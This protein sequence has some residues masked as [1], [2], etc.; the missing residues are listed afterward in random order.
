MKNI[1]KK[2]ADKHSTSADEVATEISRAIMISFNNPD[3]EVR[4]AWSHIAPHG[5]I[6]DVE[7]FIEYISNY[8]KKKIS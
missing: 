1:L 4:E 8:V 6:P 7:Q 3:P 5:E 2:V